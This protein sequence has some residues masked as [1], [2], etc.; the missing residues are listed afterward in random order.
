MQAILSN[1]YY[2][3]PLALLIGCVIGLGFSYSYF[4]P[5]IN[6]IDRKLREKAR[7]LYATDHALEKTRYE[8]VML[9]SDA[10]EQFK[11]TDNAQQILLDKNAEIVLLKEEISI[12]ENALGKKQNV[13]NIRSYKSTQNKLDEVHSRQQRLLFDEGENVEMKQRKSA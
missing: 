7:S 1:P 10:N 11:S 8:L 6:S 5:K 4:V 3:I 12:L 13:F 9:A 2:S